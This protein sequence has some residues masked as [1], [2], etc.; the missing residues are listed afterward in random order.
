MVALYMSWN[1]LQRVVMVVS[2]F[3]QICSVCCIFSTAVTKFF[4]IKQCDIL[5]MISKNT[6]K[7]VCML[8]LFFFFFFQH[9]N[10]ASCVCCFCGIWVFKCNVYRDHS[11]LGCDAKKFGPVC[12]WNFLCTRLHSIIYQRSII[13]EREVFH[14]TTPLVKTSVVSAEIYYI[15]NRHSDIIPFVY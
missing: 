14:Q 13:F 3:S 9:I 7:F 5:H 11:H 12:C 2:Y 6:G 10:T 4:S 15:V 1:V 8:D